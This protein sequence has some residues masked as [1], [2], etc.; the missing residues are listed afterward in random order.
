MNEPEN[1]E[2]ASIKKMHK[3]ASTNIKVEAAAQDKAT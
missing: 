1:S 3:P 2:S